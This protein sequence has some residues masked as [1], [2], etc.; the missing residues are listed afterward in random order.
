MHRLDQY[1]VHDRP[2]L[3]F[4]NGNSGK[5]S[6]YVETHHVIVFKGGRGEERTITFRDFKRGHEWQAYRRGG[7]WV[8]GTGNRLG[9]ED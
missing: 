1:N 6:S 3:R 7:R 8:Y 9:V 2:R 4:Y 5:S